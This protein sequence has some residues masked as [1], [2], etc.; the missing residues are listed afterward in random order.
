M[1]VKAPNKK[2]T[3]F[4][5]SSLDF[6]SLYLLFSLFKPSKSYIALYSE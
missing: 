2:A 4:E 6:V 1:F 3:I 5:D